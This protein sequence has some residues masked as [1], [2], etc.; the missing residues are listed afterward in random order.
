[1][2]LRKERAAK[3]LCPNCGEMAAP[4]YLCGKCHCLNQ[5]RKMAR[6][7]PGRFTWEPDPS[8]R[9]R[10]LIGLASWVGRLEIE[11][12]AVLKP[13]ELDFG[14]RGKPRLRGVPVNVQEELLGILARA[15]RPMSEEEIIA[16]WVKLR[17][18]PNA[19]SVAANMARVV[20]AQDKRAR[21]MAR[22]RAMAGASVHA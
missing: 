14:E 8:D 5:L 22:N 21:R 12:M 11:E 18:R 9:R 20:A 19:G 2:T 6:T 4:Y 1:M 3:G 17:P 10:K 16:A 7:M 13:R 15:G